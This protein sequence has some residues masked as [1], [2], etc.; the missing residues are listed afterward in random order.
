[1]LRVTIELLPGGRKEGAKVLSVAH[2]WNKGRGKTGFNYGVRLGSEAPGI[3]HAE[4]AYDASNKQGEVLDYPRWSESIWA[5]VAR[6]IQKT[7]RTSAKQQ[8]M[9]SFP[10]SIA[11]RVP[12][13]NSQGISYVRFQDIPDFV[14]PHFEAFMDHRTAPLIE[15][16]EDPRGCAYSWDWNS[17]LGV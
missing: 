13:L 10:A 17:F 5:L 2:I 11:N 12:V 9:G 16:E 14:R 4:Q 15:E 1:M 6:G 8:T 7:L 3:G